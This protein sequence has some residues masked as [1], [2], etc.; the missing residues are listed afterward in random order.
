M[1]RYVSKPVSFCWTLQTMI[2]ANPPE[3]EPIFVFC[4]VTLSLMLERLIDI[5]RH[6]SEHI[7][8]HTQLRNTASE[9]PKHH[10][11]SLTTIVNVYGCYRLT[12]FIHRYFSYSS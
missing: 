1:V 6:P 7:S 12:R 5:Y 9:F 3:A 11:M 10:D 4:R 2:I 8:I